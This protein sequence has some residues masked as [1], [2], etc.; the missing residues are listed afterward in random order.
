MSE[1]PTINWPGKSGMQYKYWIYLIGTP[2]KESPGNYIFAKKNQAG[3]WVPCYIGQTENLGNR[4][5]NHEKELCAKRNGATHI[6]VHGNGNAE[7][8]R[9]AEEK[10]LILQ[11]QPP[12]NDQY[13]D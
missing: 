4:L 1:A 6:H 13:V 7:Q 8:A 9:K 12:C 3:Y 5:E 10:D 11:W 2:F